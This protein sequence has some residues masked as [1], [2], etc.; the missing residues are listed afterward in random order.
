MT[1]S[2]AHYGEHAAHARL[3][4][5]AYRFMV[6]DWLADRPELLVTLGDPLLCDQPASTSLPS[7]TPTEPSLVPSSASW[8][9]PRP[10]G[11]TQIPFTSSSK[12]RSSSSS[13]VRSNLDQT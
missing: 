2:Y 13:R 4:R 9:L 6:G 3:S 8:I 5:S 11:S 1:R 10:T 7:S 12:S